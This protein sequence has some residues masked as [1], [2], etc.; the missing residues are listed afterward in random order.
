MNSYCNIYWIIFLFADSVHFSTKFAKS[1]S[2]RRSCKFNAR[3]ESIIWHTHKKCS[4]KWPSA[5]IAHT[6]WSCP[7]TNAINNS[8]LQRIFLASTV[9]IFLNRNRTLRADAQ[10]HFLRMHHRSPFRIQKSESKHNRRSATANKAKK[11]RKNHR[12]HEYNSNGRSPVDN[13]MWRFVHPAIN[14]TFDVLS[15]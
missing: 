14:N 2:R 3:F 1:Y 9:D 10:S 5:F 12:Q 7:K 6:E 13:A 11:E 15:R 8:T 4:L